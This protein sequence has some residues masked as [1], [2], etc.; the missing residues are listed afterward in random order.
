MSQKKRARF[1]IMS[2]SED[3]ELQRSRFNSSHMKKVKM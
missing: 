3:V 1:I 2:L